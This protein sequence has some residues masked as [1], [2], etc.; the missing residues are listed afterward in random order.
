MKNKVIIAILLV[1]MI[2]PSIIAIVNYNS[3]QRGAVS[4]I[5]VVSMSLVDPAGN[6]YNFS[7]DGDQEQKDMIEYFVAAKDDAEEITAIPPTIESGNYYRLSVNTSASETAYK[8]YFTA[9][10]QDCYFV[11]GDGKTYQMS[12]KSAQKFLS[13][14]YAAHL[15]E[16]GVAPVLSVTGQALMP[17][18]CHW[19]F[20][21]SEGKYTEAVSAVSDTVEAVEI[22]GGFAMDFSTEPDSFTVK[23]TDKNTGEVVFDDVYDN[24]SSVIITK[25]MSLKAEVS[26]KWYEDKTRNYYGEQIFVFDASLS[27]PAEFYAGI[28]TIQVGEFV[29]ITAV[30]VNKAENIQFTSEPD[31]GYTPK[32]FTQENGLSY[33]L[34]PFNSELSVGQYT[35]SFSYGGASQNI[36]IDLTKRDNG[37][38]TREKTYADA[39]VNSYYNDEV[40]AK[41]EEALR[42]IAQSSVEKMYFEGV[43]PEACDTKKSS[44]ATGYG[45]TITVKGTDISYFHSGVD[46]AGSAGTAVT[47]GNAGEV[48]YAD[49]LDHTGYIVVIDHGLGLKSWYAHMG[50]ITVEV[51]DV[52]AAGDKIGEFGSTGFANENGVHVGYTIFETPVCQYTLWADGN[53]KG[54]PVYKPE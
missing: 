43:F 7:R 4:N 42:P 26:A 37:F 5:N 18:A 16:N 52:V 30:N 25:N 47:A 33:A 19:N 12:E 10:T 41:A 39:I 14:G 20:I 3:E 21:N 38:K 45:H 49:Y 6:I 24:I 51:G 50:K 28:N 1:V 54:V 53:N 31:I 9:N 11:D 40:I 35:L 48:V 34:I 17:D 27:A 44:L 46:Y 15:Y 8:Y 2:I 29:C 22:E 13:S 32:F 36:N 23:L